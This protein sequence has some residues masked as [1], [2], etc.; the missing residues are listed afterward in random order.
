MMKLEFDMIFNDES[1]AKEK[2][3]SLKKWKNAKSSG[4]LSLWSNGDFIGESL[5]YPFA[6]CMSYDN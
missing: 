6:D 4:I 5:N 1:F 2:F 3:C